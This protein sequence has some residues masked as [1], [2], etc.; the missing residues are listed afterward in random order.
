MDTRKEA[1]KG[2]RQRIASIENGAVRVNRKGKGKRNRK[3]TKQGTLPGVET[4]P[5]P[6]GEMQ[7]ASVIKSPP[8]VARWL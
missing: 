7:L 4:Y 3:Q 1:A 2:K 8:G 6:S 5:T